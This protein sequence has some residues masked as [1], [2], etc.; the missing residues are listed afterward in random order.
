VP[1]F[2]K[3]YAD[4]VARLRVPSG[5]VLVA[6][7]AWFSRP[8]AISLAWGV[9]I[10]LAG[11]L[12]RGWAAG[13]L[14]KN[15][16]LATTGPYAHTRNPLYLGTALVAAGLVIASRQ[17]ALAVLFA[18]VFFLV[19]L[20]VIQLEEQHLR[21]LFPKYE[22]YARQV[23]ALRPRLRANPEH[24]RGNAFAWQLY[25]SNREYQA[26][27]GYAAGLALLVWKALG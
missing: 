23:P 20:P 13:C 1:L 2:P 14:D 16:A 24:A 8:S 17:A 26:A 9:P 10:S 3:P 15:R 19:Y 7:F 22:A 12:L 6:A 21:K 11:L 18:A 5:F 4:Q 25:R 27:A